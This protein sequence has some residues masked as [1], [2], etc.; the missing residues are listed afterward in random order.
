M[1]DRHALGAISLVGTYLLPALNDRHDPVLR[2]FMMQAS[3]EAGLAFSNASLGL[4]HAMAHVLGGLKDFPHGIC[5]GLLL[6]NVCAFNYDA[7]PERY[8]Q[9]ATALEGRSVSGPD[10]LNRAIETLV[11]STGIRSDMG[12]FH[13]TEAEIRELA[14]LSMKDACIVTNPREPGPNDVAGIYE[15]TFAS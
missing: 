12:R 15:Q 2:D 1:T 9:I 3:L 5:N 11:R 13:L 7:C 14:D 6:Q 10:A 4:I 8:D